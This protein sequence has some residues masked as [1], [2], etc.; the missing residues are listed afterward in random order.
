MRQPSQRSRRARRALIGALSVLACLLVPAAL[1]EAATTRVVAP[2]SAHQGPS[3]TTAEPC[4]YIWAIENSV[5]G[6]TVQFES[7]EYDYLGTP[8]KGVHEEA[9]LVPEKVTLEQ[10]P[11]DASRPIIKQTVAE[12]TC[13][14]S[15]L[16]LEDEVVINNLEVDQAVQPGGGPGAAV[17]APPGALIE[18]SILIGA[19]GGLYYFAGAGGEAP[20]GVRDTLVLAEAGA[21]I[22]NV[23]TVTIDL[24]NVTAIARS[25]GSV[26]LRIESK[27]SIG[28]VGTINATN[29]IAR[30]QAE[31][32]EAFSEGGQP[33]TINLHYSDARSAMELKSG[34]GAVIN[35]SDHPTHGEPLFVSTTNFHEAPGSPTIDAGTNDPASG[36][37]DLD[38]LPRTFGSATDIGA[39]EFHEGLPIATTGAATN[40]GSTSATLDGT[41]ES[42]GVATMWSFL[43]EPSAPGAGNTPVLDLAAGFLAE[44]VSSTLTNLHPATTYHYRLSAS[45]PVGI[46]SGGQ[47]SFTTAA[48]PAGIA[49][50]APVDGSLR[51]NP[52]RFRAATHG[53]SVSRAVPIGT[54]V[55][56]TD[57]EFA[58]TIFSILR[59]VVGVRSGHSCVKSPSHRRRHH[60]YASCTRYV[61]I[62]GF[63]HEDSKGTNHLHFS[64]RWKG[65]RLSPGTYRL[66]AR[67]RNDMG[68]YGPT[69]SASFTVLH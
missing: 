33:S 30:G 29:T 7:G 15:T 31:D 44:P 38:G 62:G 23:A 20:R 59:P 27:K 26:A 67:P 65:K 43:Y 69:V 13:N 51:L 32:V 6:D 3:C 60:H 49:P 54:T 2:S 17:G 63:S 39:Y 47:G 55:S 35:D 12:K 25:S 5:A 1:A 61:S 11:G 41:L 34:A 57:S 18:H 14:C 16:F 28:L 24:D 50:V 4:E 58:A 36:S 40:V 45:N 56:Y 9:L 48:A 53:A 19:G 21:A 66:T 68:L 8:D 10:A 22:Y 46:A 42:D 64:G 52:S 37:L